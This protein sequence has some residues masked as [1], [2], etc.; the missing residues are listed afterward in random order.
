MQ[1]ADVLIIGA[2]PA[3]SACAAKLVQAGK[4]VILLDKSTFPRGKLCAGWVTPQV[5][6]YLGIEPQDYPFGLTRFRSFRVSIRG[7]AFTLPTRQFAIRRWEFDHWLLNRSG[8]DIR[9]HEARSIQLDHGRFVVDEEYSAPYL[10]GAG[11]THCPVK[12]ELFSGSSPRETGAM[13]VSLEEEFPFQPPDKTCRLW[14]FEN[15][16]PGYAWYVPK[17]GG[18]LNVGIGAFESSLRT[19]SA[20]IRDQWRWLVEKLDREGLVR[21][22]AFQP[23]G[24]SYFLRRDGTPAR[25]GN[26]FLVGDSLGLATRDMGE[27]IGPAIRSGQLAAQAILQ[28]T[29]YTLDSIPQYS[30]RSILGLTRG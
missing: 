22:H 28:N 26:A 20:T 2:G 30:F 16:L 19:R 5:F 12:R 23:R 1:N 25:K 3:G 17:T 29:E 9:Q 14:F 10:V 7:F 4:N 6:E 21:G 8:A 13:I 15:H 18:F 27:G 11:G 24:H